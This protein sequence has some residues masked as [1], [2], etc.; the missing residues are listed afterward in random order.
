MALTKE[1][2]HEMVALKKSIGENFG[3]GDIRAWLKQQ[4]RTNADPI[5]AKLAR[6]LKLKAHETY[7]SIDLGDDGSLT[8]HAKSTRRLA[9]IR[10]RIESEVL[11]ELYDFWENSRGTGKLMAASE[12]APS[13]IWNCLP[14][15]ILL[16]VVGDPRRFRYRIV[17][18]A[19]EGANQ[20][21]IYGI[22]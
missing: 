7:R 22:Y 5:A 6:A 21:V 10:D 17:G 1:D 8:T 2:I 20:G 4:G 9:S 15:L 11:L 3:G 16:D 18:T 12:L 19:I 14:Y 13:K